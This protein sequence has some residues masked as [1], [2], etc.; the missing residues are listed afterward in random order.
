MPAESMEVHQQD[1]QCGE[2]DDGNDPIRGHEQ[3]L[4]R[5][6]LGYGHLVGDHS[7]TE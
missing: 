6:L 3:M 2:D 5:R 4:A 7:K 1:G